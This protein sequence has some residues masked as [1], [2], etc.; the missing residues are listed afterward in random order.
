MIFIL[1]KQVFIVLLSF[2][3]S[4]AIKSPSLKNKPCIVRPTVVD[5]N[6][7]GFKY[8]PFMIS[9]GKSGRS[10]NVLSQKI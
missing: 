7:I 8:Y 3:S 4:L 1:I 6:P 9:L 2:S 10:Y 5:L